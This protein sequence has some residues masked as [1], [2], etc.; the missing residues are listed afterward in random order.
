MQLKVSVKLHYFELPVQLEYQCFL[1]RNRT[2]VKIA[3]IN[4]DVVSARFQSRDCHVDP[5]ISESPHN[6][7]FIRL[8]RIKNKLSFRAKPEGR[9]REISA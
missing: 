4:I 6:D 5:E 8:R 3:F 1:V 9:S 2:L 7:R